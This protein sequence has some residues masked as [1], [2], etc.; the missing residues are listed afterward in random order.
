LPALVEGVLVPSI[1]FYIT[2]V[3]IGF[4]GALVAGLAWSYLALARRMLLRQRPPATLIM[5]A[6]VLTVRTILSLLTGSSFLYFVQPSAVTAAIAVLFMATALVG[7]PLTERLAYDFC[8]LDPDVVS[9]PS[10]RRFFKQISMLWG[11]VLTVNAT[12]V[13]WLLLTESLSSFVLERTAFS[14]VLTGAGIAVSVAWFSRSMKRA[15][16][17][18]HWGQQPVTVP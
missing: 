14:W 4:R 2:L 10:V 13:I 5:G 16:I 12:V 11:V 17:T 15:G 18:I 6:L 7:R 1:L 9:R 3:V 8:P